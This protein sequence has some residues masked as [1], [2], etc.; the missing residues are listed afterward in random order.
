[1][2]AFDEADFIKWSYP[3]IN[4]NA[5]KTKRISLNENGHITS[6]LFINISHFIT[7][8]LE[9]KIALW[10]LDPI[11]VQNEIP[12]LK[13]INYI[14]IGII[15]IKP[16]RDSKHAFV[17]D[18]I[19]IR[20]MDP[21]FWNTIHIFDI[22]QISSSNQETINSFEVINNELIACGRGNIL[23]IYKL[24]INGQD[25]RLESNGTFRNNLEISNILV[26]SDMTIF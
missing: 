9:G 4:Q 20:I 12:A 2:I 7:G 1:M 13:D 25:F 24:V 18:K 3:F 19:H 15:D 22:T 11:S 21:I 26:F 6:I 17:I 10:K 8:Y 23:E 16:F 5:N 14:S